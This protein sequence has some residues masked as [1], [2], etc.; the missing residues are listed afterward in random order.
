MLEK[1][2]VVTRKRGIAFSIPWGVIAPAGKL[3]KRLLKDHNLLNN[4]PI[5]IIESSISYK[6]EDVLLKQIL[7]LLVVV[8]QY[9]TGST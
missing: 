6:H 9:K 3:R 8:L 7:L 4:L 5:F 1:S 2:R